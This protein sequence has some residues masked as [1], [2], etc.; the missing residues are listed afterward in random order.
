MAEPSL[1]AGAAERLRGKPGRPR[2]DR[3]AETTAW[4]LKIAAVLPIAPR[5]LGLA[6]AGRYAG[7]STWSIRALIA[8]DKLRAVKLPGANGDMNRILIDRADLDALIEASKE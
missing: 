2:K 1:L 5:L 3:H 8:A 6:D 4:R 7:V